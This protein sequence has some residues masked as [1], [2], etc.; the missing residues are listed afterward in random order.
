MPDSRE[1]WPHA[2]LA[3]AQTS[4]RQCKSRRGACAQNGRCGGSSHGRS[5]TGGGRTRGKPSRFGWH[6]DAHIR[7]RDSAQGRAAGQ[8]EATSYPGSRT[9]GVKPVLHARSPNRPSSTSRRAATCAGSG[10]VQSQASPESSRSCGL[11][12]SPTFGCGSWWSPRP[13]QR[14][15]PACQPS[16]RQ[17]LGSSSAGRCPLRS[18]AR[19]GTLSPRSTARTPRPAQKAGASVATTPAIGRYEK[20]LEGQLY[21]HFGE[22]AEPEETFGLW[23]AALNAVSGNNWRRLTDRDHC[24]HPHHCH[25]RH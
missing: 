19:A 15:A 20:L 6:R 14:R 2:K 23:V 5:R 11:S 21:V 12:R 24:D 4:Q 16:Q 10:R 1:T 17:V 25:H 8:G 7:H 9:S 13:C 22:A 18:W 3:C